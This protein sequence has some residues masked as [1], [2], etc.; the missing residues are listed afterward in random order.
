MTTGSSSSSRPRTTHSADPGGFSGQL[1]SI[2]FG[3][4]PPLGRTGIEARAVERFAEWLAS[5][6]AMSDVRLAA[7]LK[8]VDSWLLPKLSGLAILQVLQ[9]V[10]ARRPRL[11]PALSLSSAWQSRLDQAMTYSDLCKPSALMRLAT[12]LEAERNDD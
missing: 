11:L 9:L 5:K 8:K 1:A 3:T 2:L 7:Y 10:E 4:A 6:D 12:A